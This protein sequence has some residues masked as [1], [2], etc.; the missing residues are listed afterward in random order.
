MG[1][2]IVIPAYNEEKRIPKTLVQ[3]DKYFSAKPNNYEIVVV[4]DGS[5]DRTIA[6]VKNLNLKNARVVQNPKNLGKGAAVKNGILNANQNLCLITDADLATPIAEY[7]KLEEKIQN[8]WDFVI[9][10]RNMKESNIKVKQSVFRQY[11]GRIFPFLVQAVAVSGFSDT[12]CGFKLIKTK[13]ARTIAKK[14]QING[15]AF[16][17]EMLVIAEKLGTKA[18]EV[19]IVWI[20]QRGSKVNPFKDSYKM[21]KDLLSIRLNNIKGKYGG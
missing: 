17:V 4:D 5:T 16:D 15:F 3:I 21:L 14:M 19:P 13:L 9:G 7:A 10:S 6:K 8:G 1:V 12:Q 11:L 2:S 18:I 20:D